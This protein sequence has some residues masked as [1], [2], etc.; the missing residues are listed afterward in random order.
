MRRRISLC[1]L[2]VSFLVGCGGDSKPEDKKEA[3]SSAEPEVAVESVEGGAE[4]AAE[5]AEA[6]EDA[7]AGEE[8]E[9]AEAPTPDKPTL[10]ELGD[11]PIGVETCD[12]FVKE[13]KAC[14]ENAPGDARGPAEEVLA[15]QI[16]LWRQ[17][18]EGGEDAKP[19]LEIGCKTARGRAKKSATDWGCEW[20]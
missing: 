18:A 12:D 2:A 4:E 5:A 13:W 17:T 19:A 11:D 6:G 20:K 14:L 7:Q 9:G 15:E 10:A 8:E 3:A 1:L 16:V